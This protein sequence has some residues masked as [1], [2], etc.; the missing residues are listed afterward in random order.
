MA[1]DGPSWDAALLRCCR[2]K[3]KHSAACIAQRADSLPGSDQSC[4]SSRACLW[5]GG[6]GGRDVGQGCVAFFAMPS[7]QPQQRPYNGRK[8]RA[9]GTV[10][11]CDLTACRTTSRSRYLPARTKPDGDHT[12]QSGSHD[13]SADLRRMR[14][15]FVLKHLPAGIRGHAC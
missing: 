1:C 9:P 2:A 14:D 15:C 6:G 5:E 12:R 4:L 10:M 7:L 11:L 3:L 13:R 8:V